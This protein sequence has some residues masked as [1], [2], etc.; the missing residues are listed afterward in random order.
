MKSLYNLIFKIQLDVLY[1]CE[2][3]LYFVANKIKNKK[4]SKII[5]LNTIKLA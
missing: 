1:K 5:A 2:I 3:K 4:L